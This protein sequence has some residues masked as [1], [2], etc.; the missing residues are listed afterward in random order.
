MYMY[1]YGHNHKIKLM[2]TKVKEY[3]NIIIWSVINLKIHFMRKS[4]LQ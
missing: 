3:Q 2:Y 1:T 4:I